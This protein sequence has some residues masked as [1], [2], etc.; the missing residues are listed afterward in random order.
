VSVSVI[1]QRAIGLR[2][3]TI[4]KAIDEVRLAVWSEIVDTPENKMSVPSLHY[5][6]IVS[7]KMIIQ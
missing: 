7:F 3:Q 2:V 6:S 1:G 4:I 5:R